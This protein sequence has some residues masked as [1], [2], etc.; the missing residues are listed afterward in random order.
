MKGVFW[1]E[2][3]NQINLQYETSYSGHQA[4]QKFSDI[5]SACEVNT[6]FIQYSCFILNYFKLTFIWCFVREWG[7]I[8]KGKGEES[9]QSMVNSIMK[10]S[11]LSFG[12]DHVNI[13]TFV[14]IILQKLNCNF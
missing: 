1:Q 11:E 6:I 4:R 13:I 2:A 12:K 3:A 8:L 14:L 5:V 10:S 7:S 9:V